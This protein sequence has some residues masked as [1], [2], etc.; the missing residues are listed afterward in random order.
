M[1]SFANFSLLIGLKPSEEGTRWIPAIFRRLKYNLLVV[2]VGKIIGQ[3]EPDKNRNY[4]L[5]FDID[6]SI[7]IM[8]RSDG[9]LVVERL[10]RSI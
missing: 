7:T 9:L 3:S 5:P 4:S 2:V 8:G 6:K 10:D 1:P